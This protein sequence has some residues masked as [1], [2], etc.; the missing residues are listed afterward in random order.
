[1]EATLIPCPGRACRG[2]KAKLWLKSWQK[3]T[4]H[5]ELYAKYKD[6]HERNHRPERLADHRFRQQ[7]LQLDIA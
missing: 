1:V 2:F 5:A 3:S 4:G 7:P 6:Q